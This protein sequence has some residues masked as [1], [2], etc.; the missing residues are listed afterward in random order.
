MEKPLH[1][2]CLVQ[3][4]LISKSLYSIGMATRKKENRLDLLWYCL[5]HEMVFQ[6]KKKKK[7]RL[8]QKDLFI[9]LKNI[10]LLSV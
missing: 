4:H 7:R 9:H 10:F 2:L 3:K 6:K 8:Y 1:S 5:A